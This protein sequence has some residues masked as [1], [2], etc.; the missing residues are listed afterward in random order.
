MRNNRRYREH[1]E[2]GENRGDILNRDT[3]LRV[4]TFTEFPHQLVTAGFQ[5]GLLGRGLAQLR[6]ELRRTANGAFYRL[7]PCVIA[8]KFT[9]TLRR[10]KRSVGII[11]GA[12][13]SRTSRAPT[14]I[15]A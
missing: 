1:P 8:D 2:T 14:C 5:G 7:L 11:T 13:G 4:A 3:D 15:R 6:H 12:H 10:F 9:A